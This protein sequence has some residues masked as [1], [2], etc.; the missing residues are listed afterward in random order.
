MSKI[1]I[2]FGSTTGTTEGL[3]SQ[4]AEAL[5]VAQTDIKNVGLAKVNDVDP[6]D[7]LI[8]GSSTWG[9]GDLQ[10]DWYGFLDQLETHDIKN[11][12]VAIF[13]VGDSSSFPDTFCNAVGTIYERLCNKT[14]I[15]GKTP[16]DGYSYDTSSAE[17]DGKFVGLLLDET[18]ES[19]KS[20]DRINAW[21]EQLKTEI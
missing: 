9:A 3:S 12:K 6:Y 20:S 15:I 2:F 10:D 14:T 21:A 1:G 8:F 13:G 11:K 7:V 16:T 17:V 5:G 4:I 18:N 19:E